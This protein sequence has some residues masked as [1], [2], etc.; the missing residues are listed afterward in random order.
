VRR[1]CAPPASVRCAPHIADTFPAFARALCVHVRRAQHACWPLDGPI[2]AVMTTLRR[3]HGKCHSAAHTR[4]TPASVRLL[5]LPPLASLHSRAS[6]RVV[7]V[8][9]R[10]RRGRGGLAAAAG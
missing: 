6:R 1:A 8:S 3:P 4:H 10:A 9:R 7:R 5:T 2:V